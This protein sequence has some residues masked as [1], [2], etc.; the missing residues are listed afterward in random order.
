MTNSLQERLHARL[1]A[2]DTR[3]GEIDVELLGLCP[4]KTRAVQLN[5]QR[6]ELVRELRQLQEQLRGL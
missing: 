3:I 1:L 2:I 6:I 5:Q 4:F